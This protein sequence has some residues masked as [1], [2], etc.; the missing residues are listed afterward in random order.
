M[1]TRGITVQRIDH[2]EVYVPDRY[3]A[4]AWY[5]QTLG[6]ELLTDPVFTWRPSSPMARY[7]SATPPDPCW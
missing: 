2:I 1:T 3:E 5:E 7:S 4:V 6:L